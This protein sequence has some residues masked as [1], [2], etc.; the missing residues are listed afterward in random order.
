MGGS[1]VNPVTEGTQSKKSFIFPAQHQV[2]V[3]GNVDHS[4]DRDDVVQDLLLVGEPPSFLDGSLEAT[5]A[6]S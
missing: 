5:Q 1:G 2:P 4:G 6:S 3:L